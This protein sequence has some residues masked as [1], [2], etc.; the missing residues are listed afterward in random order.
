MNSVSPKL[1]HV[2]LEV[3]SYS[4]VPLIYV[5]N[6]HFYPKLTWIWKYDVILTSIALIKVIFNFERVRNI[7]ICINMSIPSRMIRFRV[8]WAESSN[9]GPANQLSSSTVRW[10]V[11]CMND[12]YLMAPVHVILCDVIMF[13]VWYATWRI[14]IM[15]WFVQWYDYI[16]LCYKTTLWNQCYV[17]AWTSTCHATYIIWSAIARA[18]E[19]L[20]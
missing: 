12:T 15:M 20:E 10:L 18:R 13:D 16:I 14:Y 4:N 7:G 19:N 1:L 6:S 3:V 8:G 17:I 5:N 11:C 9:I 2:S